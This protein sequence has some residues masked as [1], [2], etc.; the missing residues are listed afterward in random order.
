MKAVHLLDR[1][2]LRLL[3]DP[4]RQE[5]LGLLCSEELSTAQLA[6]RVR[7]PP[8]NLYYHTDRLREAGLIR[9]VRRRRVRGAVEKFYRAVAHS[10]T[11]PPALLRTGGDAAQSELAAVIEAM[12]QSVL[13][14]FLESVERGL[15]GSGPGQAVPMVTSL[16][17][18]TTGARLQELRDRLEQCVRAMQQESD[19]TSDDAVEYALFDMFFPLDLASDSSA[20]GRSEGGRSRPRTRL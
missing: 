16:T 5:I 14:R 18:R 2:Q 20:A 8:S 6:G 19:P 7:R 1:E 4:L 9:V 3:A 15:I 13:T 17:V 10:F 12:M 11:A